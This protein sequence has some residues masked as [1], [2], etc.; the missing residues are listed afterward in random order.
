V[1]AGYVVDTADRA[2]ALAA[3]RQP[4]ET[5]MGTNRAWEHLQECYMVG[6][7]DD[8][9]ARLKLLESK[10]LEHVT[11]QPAAPEMAQLDLWMDKII[12]P[13]FRSCA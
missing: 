4:M 3:Q 5:I 9:V 8:I 11:I 10:G 7:I 1:Q 13:H 2:T 12:T 6:T